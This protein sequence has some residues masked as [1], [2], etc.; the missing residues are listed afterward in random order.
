MSS[1]LQRLYYPLLLQMAGEYVKAKNKLREEF[2]YF[3]K[4]ILFINLNR[5]GYSFIPSIFN[6]MNL[7][8]YSLLVKFTNNLLDLIQLRC[9]I[10]VWT[11]KVP[12][13]PLVEIPDLYDN[14]DI[15]SISSIKWG[16]K[17]KVVSSTKVLSDIIK[18][19]DSGSLVHYYAFGKYPDKSKKRVH[20]PK[21]S[22]NH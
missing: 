14:L 22:K 21:L 9:K 5:K 16:E 8:F 3:T 10:Y 18:N 4:N 11:T 20:E 7:G 13:I 17:R 15:K 6:F 2:K 19:A 1:N 12:R